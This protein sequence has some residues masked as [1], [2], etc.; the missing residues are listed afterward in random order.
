MKTHYSNCSYIYL[1]IFIWKV[2]DLM[3]IL[4]DEKHLGVNVVHSPPAYEPST[5]EFQPRVAI[6]ELK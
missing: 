3:R 2:N 1:F 5:S 4:R 6:T